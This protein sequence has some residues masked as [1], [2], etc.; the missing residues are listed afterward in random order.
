MA[1][2]LFPIILFS[3]PFVHLQC[4]YTLCSTRVIVFRTSWNYFTVTQCHLRVLVLVFS[5]WY[6]NYPEYIS[7]ICGNYTVKNKHFSFFVK[8]YFP[9][10]TK[11][12]DQDKPWSTIVF[13]WFAWKKTNNLFTLV[14]QRF[15]ESWKIIVNTDFCY[16]NLCAKF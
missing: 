9:Y 6:V 3:G 16:S 15:R 12:R 10:S 14:Y 13:V 1:H 8:M 5:L 4:I 2:V 7:C 11:L